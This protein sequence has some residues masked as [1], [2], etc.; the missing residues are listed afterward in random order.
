MEQI[1]LTESTDALAVL[2]NKHINISMICPSCKAFIE[3]LQGLYNSPLAHVHRSFVIYDHN[4]S[5][6]TQQIPTQ[7]QLLLRQL[8]TKTINNMKSTT[9]LI[10]TFFAF[11]TI[12]LPVLANDARGPKCTPGAPDRCSREDDY[13]LSHCTNEGKS[14][15]YEGHVRHILTSYLYLCRLLG[16]VHCLLVRQV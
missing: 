15:L 16:I 7:Q 2:L 3:H 14:R 13:T 11:L 6:T 9:Y 4:I 1:M 12:V 10:P 5:I 8:L